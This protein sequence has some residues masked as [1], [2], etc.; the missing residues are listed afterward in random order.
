V[1]I[2]WATRGKSWGFRFLRTGGIPNPLAVYERAFVGAEGAS[3]TFERRAETIAVRFTDPDGRTD[4]AG[5]V[6]QHDFV[7][8]SGETD[9]LRNVEDA[10]A[11]LWPMVR[12]DF[13]DFWERPTAPAPSAP[14]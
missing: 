5:R 1:N 13:D 3:M 12:E 10:R 6:I 9:D 2:I 11:I 14:Q 7:I 8:L 4:R